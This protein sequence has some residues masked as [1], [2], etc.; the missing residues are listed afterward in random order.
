MAVHRK[1]V[2]LRGGKRLRGQCLRPGSSVS[3]YIQAWPSV[4]YAGDR[5]M[6]ER[7]FTVCQET[8][9]QPGHNNQK[10]MDECKDNNE[11]ENRA[12]HVQPSSSRS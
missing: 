8:P 3:V 11:G 4:A 5:A 7:I 6:I 2:E 9:A 10:R 12:G 1:G